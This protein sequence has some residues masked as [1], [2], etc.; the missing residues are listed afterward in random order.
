MGIFKIFKLLI[1]NV[2]WRKEEEEEEN[3]IVHDVLTMMDKNKT[4]KN[5]YEHFSISNTL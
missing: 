1:Q 2:S 5:G 4:E 3:L